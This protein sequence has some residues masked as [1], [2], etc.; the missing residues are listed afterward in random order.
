MVAP[1]RPPS[2][3]FVA[4]LR[5]VY[6]PIGFSKGYN[7]VLWFIF[8]GGLLGFVLARLMFLNYG[9]IFCAKHPAGGVKGA[10]PGECWSYNSKTYLKVGIK[11]HLYTILP[12]GL[13]AVFQ[14]IPIIRYK[15]ILFHRINGYAILLLSLVGTAGAL[16]I[17]RVSFGGGIETQTVVG[18]LAILFLGSLSIAYYNI[19]KLQLEQHRAWMLRAWIY[20]GSIITC[21]IIMI[22]AASIVSLWGQF[23]KA[24]RCDKLASFYKSNE[25]LLAV[26]P[27]CNAS[28]SYVAVKANINAGNAGNAAAALDLSFGMSVWL[29]LALH[30]IGVEI[31]LHLTPAEFERLRKISYRKQLEAGFKAP[32]RAGLTA[33][34]LGDSE[35]WVHVPDDRHANSAST[36]ALLPNGQKTI[37]S[38][39]LRQDHQHEI[40]FSHTSSGF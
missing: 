19:K 2:N 40:S 5:R 3:A 13:L 7:F 16:M 33:D 34:R 30:A 28:T 25:A 35:L 14:F 23:Y 31:Y 8:A 37:D 17:A 15:V 1:S 24:E 20:A 36:Y 27:S 9:G 38:N 39:L 12:A 26:Y 6:N 10:A 4:T 22:S 32:G 29:A 21:R 11:L 18:L